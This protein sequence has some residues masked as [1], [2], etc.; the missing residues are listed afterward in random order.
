MVGSEQR[1]SNIEGLFFD[2]TGVTSLTGVEIRAPM[3][4]GEK[5][6]RNSP[7][8]QVR[9][10]EHGYPILRSIAASAHSG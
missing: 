4:H 10:D 8:P 7:T 5:L 1:G 6:Q 9:R 2:T 3:S